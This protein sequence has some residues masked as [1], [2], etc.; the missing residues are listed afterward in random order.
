MEVKEAYNIWAHQYDTNENKTRDLE[1]QVLKDTLS[2][3]RFSSCLAI[4][5]GTGKNTEWLLT[6]ADQVTAVDLS[7]E[8]L[9]KAKSK[10]QSPDVHFIQAGINQAWTFTKRLFDLVTFSLLQQKRND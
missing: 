2:D 7:E 4:G 1:A 8:M 5:C 9:A 3:L 6:R 10:I